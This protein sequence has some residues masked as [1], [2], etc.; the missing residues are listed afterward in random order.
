MFALDLFLVFVIVPLALDFAAASTILFLE[1][2]SLIA[3][4]AIVA[5]SAPAAVPAF[6]FPGIGQGDTGP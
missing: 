3:G 4:F 5:A 1:G 2:S 6:V